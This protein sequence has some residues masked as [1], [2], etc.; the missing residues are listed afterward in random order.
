MKR[1]TFVGQSMDIVQS[2][3]KNPLESDGTKIMQIM[4]ISTNAQIKILTINLVWVLAV[5][6]NSTIKT[7]SNPYVLKYLYTT[8]TE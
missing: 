5:I 8:P 2:W 1:Y 6:S 7:S 3:M 4:E